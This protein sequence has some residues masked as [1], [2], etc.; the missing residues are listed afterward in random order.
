MAI[1]VGKACHRCTCDVKGVGG[2]LGMGIQCMAADSRKPLCCAMTDMQR[3]V[4]LDSIGV[5]AQCS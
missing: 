4:V 2:H 5:P 3:G 1:A